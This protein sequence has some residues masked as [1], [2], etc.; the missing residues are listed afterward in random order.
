MSGE[1]GGGVKAHRFQHSAHTEAGQ[2]DREAGIDISVY[3]RMCILHRR[4][5][6]GDRDTRISR[7]ETEI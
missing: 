5:I 6:L 2:Q 4:Y 7:I 1:G 3:C